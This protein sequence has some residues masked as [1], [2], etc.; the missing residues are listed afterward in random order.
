MLMG[1]GVQTALPSTCSPENSG[2]MTALA[3]DTE[4]LKKERRA[5]WRDDGSLDA[6]DFRLD[7][8]PKLQRLPVRAI[9]AAMGATIS[10]GSK[11]RGGGLAPHRH[12]WKVPM[13][14]AQKAG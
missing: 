1:C 2:M 4:A 5:G 3:L 7:I 10:H 9:A 11:V 6:V 13:R 12:H 8:L 14:V